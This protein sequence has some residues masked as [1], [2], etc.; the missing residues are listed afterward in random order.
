VSAQVEKIPYYTNLHFND[1]FFIVAE[2]DDKNNYYAVNISSLKDD[3]ERA[4][5]C[6]IAFAEPKLVRLDS[7]NKNIAWFKA[8]NKANNITDVFLSLK[9]KTI[10]YSSSLSDIQKQQWLKAINK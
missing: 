9:E 6:E 4:Y 5:F 8:N 7:G 1:S 2:H 3:F 10:L